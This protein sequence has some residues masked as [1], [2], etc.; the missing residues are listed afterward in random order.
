MGDMPEFVF[1][2]CLPEAGGEGGPAFDRFADVFV[3]AP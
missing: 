2:S 3:P 1:L